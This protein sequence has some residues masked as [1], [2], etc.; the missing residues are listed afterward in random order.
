MEM[1]SDAMH[2]VRLARDFL[3]GLALFMVICSVNLANGTPPDL[4]A[5]ASAVR[6]S[7]LAALLEL[8]ACWPAVEAGAGLM[9]G[10]LVEHDRALVILGLVFSGLVAFNLWFVRHVRCVYTAPRQGG[11]NGG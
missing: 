3:I 10:A 2:T 9:P 6:T 5:F 4:L 8:G 11:W 7:I 1:S